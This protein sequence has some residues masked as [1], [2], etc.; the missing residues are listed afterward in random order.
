VRLEIAPKNV[1]NC[2]DQAYLVLKAS[3]LSHR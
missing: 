3:W 2:P 1:S